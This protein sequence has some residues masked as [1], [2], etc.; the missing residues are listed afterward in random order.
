ML[1]VACGI[2]ANDQVVPLVWTLVSIRKYRMVEGV[3][4][5]SS[6]FPILRAEN[7]VSIPDREK[8]IASAVPE[9][10]PAFCQHIADN[11]QQ[12]FGNKVRPL[13]F[14]LENYKS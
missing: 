11:L 10:F 6:C 7:H 12:I 14:F 9:V 1:L 4:P 5:I 13:F 8:G 2:D 3:F